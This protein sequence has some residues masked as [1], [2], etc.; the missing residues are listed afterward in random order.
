MEQPPIRTPDGRIW[1]QPDPTEA[2]PRDTDESVSCDPTALEPITPDDPRYADLAETA[3]D[4]EA[5]ERDKIHRRAYPSGRL[6]RFQRH[7][8]AVTHNRHTA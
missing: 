4:D 8:R 6:A 5:W 2:R 7:S 3:I 1:V